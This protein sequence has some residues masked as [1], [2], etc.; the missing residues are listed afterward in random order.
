MNDRTFSL[1]FVWI[2]ADLGWFTR[3]VWDRFGHGWAYAMA[4]VGFGALLGILRWWMRRLVRHPHAPRARLSA[5]QSHETRPT[6]GPDT[7]R[8]QNGGDA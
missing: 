7:P 2:T 6:V 3:V 8:P 5:S 1:L 4:F